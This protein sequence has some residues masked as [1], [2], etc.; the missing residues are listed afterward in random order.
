VEEEIMQDFAKMKQAF[1]NDDVTTMS[2][3]EDL[4]EYGS[5]WNHAIFA[6]A[7]PP[8]LLRPYLL[9]HWSSPLAKDPAV[10]Q[11]LYEYNTCFD[12]DVIDNAHYFTPEVNFQ[13]DMLVELQRLVHRCVVVIVTALLPV[14]GQ[15]VLSLL[16]KLE[17]VAN[18]TGKM[19]QYIFGTVMS[20]PLQL[21]LAQ[22]HQAVN[23]GVL[24][25]QM[26]L[27]HFVVS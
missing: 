20:T 18:S 8:M 27:Q 7:K 14:S 2:Q 13:L 3:D 25:I 17:N 19:Y 9:R 16:H 5:M 23:V 1:L 15:R 24:S 22:K 10:L 11:L 6:I 4:I 21:Y 26:L 12:V